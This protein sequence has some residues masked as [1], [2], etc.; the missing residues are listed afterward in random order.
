MCSLIGG[1][2]WVTTM[3]ERTVEGL[4][5]QVYFAV[6]GAAGGELSIAGGSSSLS[7]GEERIS[8]YHPILVCV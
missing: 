6:G 2:Q 5:S 7:A 1:K 8:R 3:L 4:P